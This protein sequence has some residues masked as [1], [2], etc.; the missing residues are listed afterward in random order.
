MP[1]RMRHSVSPSPLPVRSSCGLR[2]AAQ[3]CKRDA[4]RN[5]ARY[6]NGS[7]LKRMQSPYSHLRP[8][9]SG[10]LCTSSSLLLAGCHYCYVRSWFGPRAT[11]AGCCFSV[12]VP[13]E[14]SPDLFPFLDLFLRSKLPAVGHAGLPVLAQVTG[15]CGP[16][17][18]R[19]SFMTR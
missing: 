9:P 19:C 12:H 15:A 6:C 3:L 17:C 11:A 16:E 4:H 18:I 14:M 1:A 2:T 13:P 5:C 8:R 10:K 7:V